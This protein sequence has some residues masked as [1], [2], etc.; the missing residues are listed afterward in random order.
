MQLDDVVAIEEW[1]NKQIPDGYLTFRVVFVSGIF[2]EEVRNALKAVEPD[3]SRD[4]ETRE[5]FVRAPS[6]VTWKS[7]KEYTRYQINLGLSDLDARDLEDERV[8]PARKML[9]LYTYA[10]SNM[11]T[12]F[13][14]QTVR[15][16][17]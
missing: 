16:A 6:Q 5:V 14:N 10:S 9:I 15:L 12:H 7:V 2:A 11:V 17:I 13:K 8:I 1:K 3:W 4:E